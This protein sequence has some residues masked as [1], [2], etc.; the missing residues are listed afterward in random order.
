MLKL[1]DVS[2]SGYYDWLNRSESQRS[3]DDRRLLTKIYRSFNQSR[4]TY[5][6][7][8]ILNDLRADGEA[9][10]ERRLLRLM[11]THSIKPKTKRKYRVTTN[12][13]HNDPIYDNVLNREFTADCPEQRWVSDITYVSTQ[14]GWLYLATVLDLFSRRIVGWA[15]SSRIDQQLVIEA[16][17]KALFQRKRSGP[18]LLHSD[19]GSQYASA[20]YQKLVQQNQITYSM[21]RKG[22]CWDNAAME[23]FFGKLKVECV[24]HEKFKTRAQARACVF[25]Y[26]EVFYNRKRRHS[27]LNYMSPVDYEKLMAVA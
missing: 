24:H 27:K 2:R 18:L 21:S 25:E 13:K 22:N 19:R 7:R 23:S 26:L 14:E 11:R 6:Y 3:R 4:Q 5:G 15:T 1:F 16:L 8:S 9:C 12:S 17:E 10:G 20:R